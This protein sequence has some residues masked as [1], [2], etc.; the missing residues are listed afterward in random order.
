MSEMVGVSS[1]KIR[2][3]VDWRMFLTMH[4][5]RS[6]R[7]RN[8]WNFRMCSTSCVP[9]RLHFA[10]RPKAKVCFGSKRQVGLLRNFVLEHLSKT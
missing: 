1:F 2:S 8:S 5:H 10:P 7:W 9:R 4:W 3:S 6:S